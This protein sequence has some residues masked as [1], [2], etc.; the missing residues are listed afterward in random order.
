[1]HK[2]PKRTTI[3][4]L[5]GASSCRETVWQPSA[6]IYRT[7]DGWLVKFDLAGVR[8][9]DIIVTVQ[10]TGVTVSGV[11]RDW[12]FEEGYRYYSMEIAYSR[13]ERCINLPCDLERAR[14]TSEYREG[15]LLLRVALE[16]G[17]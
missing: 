6:D 3:F 4:F 9:E 7:C 13:F 17:L 12:V 8:P 14:I 10:G 1:M 11:R 16:D 15:M 2:R 5:P